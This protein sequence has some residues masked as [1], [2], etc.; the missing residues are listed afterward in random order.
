MDGIAFGDLGLVPTFLFINPDG[1]LM[2]HPE[3]VP[4]FNSWRWI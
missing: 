1:H 4:I 2:P 3:L